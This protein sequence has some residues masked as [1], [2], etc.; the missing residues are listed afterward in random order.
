MRM[1]KEEKEALLDLLDG[2]SDNDTNDWFLEHL[3]DKYQ[4]K[5]FTMFLKLRLELRGY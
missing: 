4:D 5:Y 3:H 2:M 1:T